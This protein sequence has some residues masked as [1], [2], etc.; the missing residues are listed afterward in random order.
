M[1]PDQMNTTERVLDEL[2]T[3]REKQDEKW[4]EQNHPIR[5]PASDEKDRAYYQRMA[6]AWKFTNASRVQVANERDKTPDRNCAWDGVA[7]EELFEALAE[8]DPAKIRAELVQ[9]GA[10]VV[11]MIEYLDRNGLGT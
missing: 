6:D 9:A 4:G 1:N 5:W 11:A 8:S 7:L 2:F 10:V 3:E